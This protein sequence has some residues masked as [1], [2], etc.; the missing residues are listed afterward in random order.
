MPGIDLRQEIERS[1]GQSPQGIGELMGKK[2]NKYKGQAV[3][4]AM[5][6][7]DG[8]REGWEFALPC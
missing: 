8:G 4:N 3:I 5:K 2:D 7:I 6:K 1:I